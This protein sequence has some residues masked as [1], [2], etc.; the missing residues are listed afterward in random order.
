[1][2]KSLG[3]YIKWQNGLYIMNGLDRDEGMLACKNASVVDYAISTAD[4]FN[5]VIVF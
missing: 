1:M 3:L 4:L 2:R 5:D